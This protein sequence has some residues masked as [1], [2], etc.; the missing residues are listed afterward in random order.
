MKK[1]PYPARPSVG[2]GECSPGLED[3]DYRRLFDAMPAP[4]LIL[5]PD[6]LIAAVNEAYLKAT[7]TERQALLGRYIFDAFPDN[8]DDPEAQSTA[9]LSASFA[10]VIRD[11][12]PDV[13]AIQKYDIRVGEHGEFE[14]RYWSPVNTPVFD[15]RG[16][17]THIIH[18]V[19]DVTRIMFER[20][21]LEAAE[22]INDEQGIEIRLA[23]ARL[24]E[25]KLELERERD[26]RELFVLTL[27]HDLRT[28]LTAAKF[29]SQ[30]L[31]SKSSNPA[32]ALRLS[33]RILASLDRCDGMIADLL[34]TSRLRSGKH[35]V[36]EVETLELSELV[37]DTLAELSTVYG[38][39]FVL[40]A[41]APIE[42]RWSRREVS[43]MLENLCINAVKYGTPAR[44]VRVLLRRE[45]NLAIIE[46]HNEGPPIPE[47][48]QARLFEPYH[49]RA[50]HG[51][52]AS[53][54]GLGLTVVNGIASAHGGDVVVISN[55]VDGT[56]FR[57]TL[58]IDSR[59]GD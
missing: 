33:A 32:D 11:G 55:E 58:P 10:R 30:L 59:Q 44:P 36:I 31:L 9:N 57:V 56:T 39:R 38:D 47:E 29:A 52:T 43:R 37:Q 1:P 12:V 49:R 23:N 2:P 6:L 51:G 21:R 16:V 27:S 19:E 26:L 15:E 35:L 45:A 42:G 25:A 7:R 14:E 17:L 53:G 48:E 41:A 22:M 24:R 8:P 28:P 46:V 50:A 40:V 4:S 20:S 5:T 3:A 18:R 34:D 54:W 13:M